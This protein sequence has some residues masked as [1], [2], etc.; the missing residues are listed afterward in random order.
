MNDGILLA[1]ARAMRSAQRLEGRLQLLFGAQNAISAISKVPKPTYDEFVALVHSGD[2]KTFGKALHGVFEKLPELGLSPFPDSARKVFLTT[3]QA[4]NFLAHH[5][6]HERRV[7]AEDKNAWPYLIAELDWYSEVF[8]T[9]VPRIDKWT[10]M[11]LNRIGINADELGSAVHKLREGF[12]PDQRRKHLSCSRIC[13]NRSVSRFLKCRS[14]LSNT[15]I[16]P[17]V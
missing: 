1:Y 17:P 12:T 6:F 7:L 14:R 8:D 9:W 5:Y 10:D 13:L 4:R 16:D 3:I 2:E 15:P 11:L